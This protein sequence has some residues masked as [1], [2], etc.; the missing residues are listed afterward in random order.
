[1][2]KPANIAQ[3]NDGIEVA[4]PFY[5]V[6]ASGNAAGTQGN[7]TATNQLVGTPVYGTATL[8][9]ATG[10]TATLAA[11]A[12]KTTYINGFY[13][14]VAHTSAGVVAGQVTLSLDS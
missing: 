11:N 6:D 12:T 7:P 13:V 14:S 10:G 9:A 2:T 8:A 5:K 3:I 4:H 1:M